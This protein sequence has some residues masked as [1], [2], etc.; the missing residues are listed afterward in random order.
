M[1][2]AV[3]VAWLLASSAS[4]LAQALEG[5]RL[6]MAWT[7][8][9]ST[10]ADRIDGLPTRELLGLE[11]QGSVTLESRV[12]LVL[13]GDIDRETLESL[14]VQVGTQAGGVTT[15][16]A[17]LGLV[18]TLAGVPGVETLDL[19]ETL[20]PATDVSTDEIEADAVWGSNGGTPPVYSGLS[21]RGVVVG[22]VDTG[23]DLDHA[24]FRTSQNKTRVKFAW[25]Q[26]WAGNPPPGFAYGTQYTESAINAGQATSFQDTDGHGT[27]LL[28]I[29]GGDGSATGGGRAAYRFVGVAPEADLVVVK[30]DF[31]EAGIIDGVNYVF[32]R[33]AALGKP[34]VVC[35]AVTLHKGGHDGSSPLDAAVSALT[36]PGKLVAAAA[37]N[38]GLQPV[39][40]RV[41]AALS[42]TV[43]TSFEVPPYTALS[44]SPAYVIVE[45]WHDPGASFR[46]KLRA[47]T[48]AETAWLEPGQTTGAVTVSAG[49]YQVDNARTVNS[50]GAKQILISLWRANQTSPSPAV[51]SWTITL[52]RR[53]GT[54]SGIADFWVSS[55]FLPTTEAPGFLDPDPSMTVASPA[56]A[57]GVIATGAYATK[58]QWTNGS[59]ITSS[60][61]GVPLHTVADFSSRGPRRDGVMRPDVV[62]PGCGVMA[63]LSADSPSSNVWKDPDLVHRIQKGT[64][65]AAAHTTGG[66]ALLL[67]VDP[68]ATPDEARAWLVERARADAYTG[69][70][71]NPAYGYGKLHLS[72]GPTSVVEVPPSRFGFRAPYPNPSLA[73]TNFEFSLDSSVVLR[74]P[75]TVEVQIFDVSGRLVRALPGRWE[76]GPQRI[77]W[78][79]RTSFGARAPGGMYVTRLVAGNLGAVQKIVRL[80]Q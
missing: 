9:A 32:Q 18:P 29:A 51:G 19:A 37:G 39:H 2:S 26:T 69:L 8:L 68:G 73:A 61:P 70:V 10:P 14:G 78:D 34:A 55:W 62:A 30:T 40:D 33:A 31:T 75:G 71:P 17:P 15:A 7:W 44:T 79:G 11:P 53:T 4:A 57:D 56:T 16:A 46:V 74:G 12:R 77:V 67:E 66:L 48:G 65:Q 21:G 60:Y 5:P 24:D 13:T 76:E 20:V 72:L 45:G 52:S 3:A 1:A 36:G 38:D 41:S 59:G 43:T 50:R 64:S 28:G 80:S 49:T 54:T 47:P 22:I 25:D 35:L 23:A 58:V 42:Q 27:H 63:A 6:R